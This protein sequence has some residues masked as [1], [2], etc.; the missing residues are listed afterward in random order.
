MGQ[1]QPAKV[2]IGEDGLDVAVRGSAGRGVAVVA[3]RGIADQLFH[4]GLGAENVPDQAGR[5]VIVKVAAVEG[6]DAGR[7]LAA[8][9]MQ[10]QRA[11]GGGI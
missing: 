9:G 4:H 1:R 11:V 5:A 6:D 10:A 3:D 7:F 2:E 8:Q